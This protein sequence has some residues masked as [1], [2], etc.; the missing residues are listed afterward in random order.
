MASGGAID[1]SN[2]APATLAPTLASSTPKL[3][4]A[5]GPARPSRIAKTAMVTAIRHAPK[6]V[7]SFDVRR[8]PGR[9][10]ADRERSESVD[11]ACIHRLYVSGVPTL[12]HEQPDDLLG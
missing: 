6:P 10:G 9:V 3:G 4:A 7:H 8:T 11:R 5:Y 12:E 2:T 1:E